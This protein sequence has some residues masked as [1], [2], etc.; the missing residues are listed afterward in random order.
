[1]DNNKVENEWGE[2]VEHD[3]ALL[4]SIEEKIG[5]TSTGK[6]SFRAEVYRR[7]IRSKS[8]T[9]SYEYE[10]HPKLKEALQKQ[11][12]DERKDVI[13]LTVSTR[14]P[15]AEALKKLNEVV[16]VLVDKYGYNEE[17]AN[18]LLRYVSNIMSKSR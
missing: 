15:D 1:L 5:I 14:N 8:E 17:S 11:L 6:E 3:E 10:S 4:R 7:M 12:F 2:L 13:K 9:G 18:E 16:C